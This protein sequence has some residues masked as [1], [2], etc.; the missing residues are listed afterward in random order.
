MLQQKMLNCVVLRLTRYV[1]VADSYPGGVENL[2]SGKRVREHR[3][4]YTLPYGEGMVFSTASGLESHLANAATML[5]SEISG[6][7]L[8]V[9][10]NGLRVSDRVIKY[11]EDVFGEGFPVAGYDFLKEPFLTNNTGGVV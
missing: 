8:L 11:S 2:R 4:E 6:G 7:V 5:M 9:Y 3:F 1:T 10:R